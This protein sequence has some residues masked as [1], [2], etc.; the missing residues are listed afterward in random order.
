MN[1]QRQDFTKEEAAPRLHITIP[2]RSTTTIINYD[3]QAHEQPAI[4]H[5]PL[6]T[7]NILTCT[8]PTSY[9]YNLSVYIV[10]FLLITASVRPSKL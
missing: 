9:L 4:D 2:E 3:H 5:V 6:P 7:T 8:T 10:Y 1:A